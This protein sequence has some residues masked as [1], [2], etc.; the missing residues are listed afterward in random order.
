MY[1]DR[2][3]SEPRQRQKMQELWKMG[4]EGILV[5]L[6]KQLRKLPMVQQPTKLI[7]P[8]QHSINIT[9]DLSINYK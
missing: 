7:I 8:N 3:T 2:I 9:T 1:F 6:L 5:N 4:I